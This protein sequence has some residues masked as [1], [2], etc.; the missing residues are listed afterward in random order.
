[1]IA[2]GLLGWGTSVVW[3]NAASYPPPVGR[4]Q[5][6]PAPPAVS[7]PAGVASTGWHPEGSEVVGQDVRFSNTCSQ[8][9]KV[10]VNYTTPIGSTA[11]GIYDFSPGE[12]SYLATSQNVRIKAIRQFFF[13]ARMTGPERD[14]TWSGPTEKSV[15]GTSYRMRSVAISNTE[16]SLSVDCNNFWRIVAKNSCQEEVTVALHFDSVAPGAGFNTYSWWTIAPNAETT[17][18]ITGGGFVETASETPSLPGRLYFFAR[19]KS[20]RWDKRESDQG[21]MFLVDGE[22]RN[23]RLQELKSGDRGP[24]LNFSCS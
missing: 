1:L 13:F 17:L 5:S 14:Y 22:Y 10:Y 8:P 9:I 19:S 3:K 12:S 4:I 20:H 15:D 24:H 6:A 23:M 18:S 11:T 2:L 7:A 16:A 21:K